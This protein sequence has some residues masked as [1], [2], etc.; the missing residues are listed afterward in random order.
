MEVNFFGGDNTKVCGFSIKIVER[1]SGMLCRARIAVN[2]KEV[3]S[4]AYF[5]IEA[6]LN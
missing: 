5:N 4:R 1:I 2:S 3:I 6:A